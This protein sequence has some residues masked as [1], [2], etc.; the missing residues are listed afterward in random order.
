[1][2]KRLTRVSPVQL[3]IVLA[4]L[5]ALI[6]LVLVI[7]LGALSMM[8]NAF[9]QQHGVHSVGASLFTGAFLFLMPVIYAVLG[10]VGG[11]IV[12]VIYNVVASFTGG[13]EVTVEDVG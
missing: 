6:S 13:I 2:K 3:G 10:F 4:V 7:P 8:S 11:V 5:Y 12:A 9:M 1:M